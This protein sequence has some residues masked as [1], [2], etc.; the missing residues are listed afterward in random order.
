MKCHIWDDGLNV[1][2]GV[3][4]K[5]CRAFPALFEVSMMGGQMF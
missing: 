2:I 3:F 1:G 5:I 4:H